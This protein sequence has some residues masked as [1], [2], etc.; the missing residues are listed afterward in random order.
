MHA[1]CV[2]TLFMADQAFAMSEFNNNVFKI[3]YVIMHKIWM[4]GGEAQAESS[5]L[6][7]FTSYSERVEPQWEPCWK[8]T[9]GAIMLLL[10]LSS[11][12]PLVDEILTNKC[13]LFAVLELPTLSNSR[14]K[15]PLIRDSQVKCWSGEAKG[16]ITEKGPCGGHLSSALLQRSMSVLN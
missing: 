1:Q 15:F 7:S 2:T 8:L 10:P 13:D 9:V 11:L 3:S 16:R 6:V 14:D 5:C 4:M 12:A